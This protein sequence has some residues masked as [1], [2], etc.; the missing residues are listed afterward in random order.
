M[1]HIVQ[2]GISIDDTLIQK[3]VAENAEK[4]IIQQIEEKVSGE[5]FGYDWTGKPKKEYMAEWVQKKVDGFLREHRQEIINAAALVL[6]D[7]LK[8][9]KDVKDMAKRVVSDENH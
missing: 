6:C 2:F 7:S 4:Q 1:E 5:L 3:R 8:R 9:T